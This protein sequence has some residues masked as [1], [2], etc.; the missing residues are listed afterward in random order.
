MDRIGKDGTAEG[1]GPAAERRAA[2]GTDHDRPVP[3]PVAARAV[4][5]VAGDFVV[6]VNPVDGSEIELCPPPALRAGRG[7]PAEPRPRTAA[8]RAADRA[9]GPRPAPLLERGA[10]RERLA[11]LLGRGRSVRLT[12][13]EGSGRTA[14]L[15][16]VA[17]DCAELAPEGVVRLNGLGRTPADLLHELHAAVRPAERHR[18]GRERLH[19]DIRETGAVV[20]LDDLEFGGAALGE[21]LAAAP[22][23]AFVLAPGPQA[24][25]PAPEDHLDEVVLEG[26]SRGASLE[27]LERAVGRPLTEDETNWAG[28]LWF[29]S[30]GLPLRFVQAGALLRQCDELRSDPEAFEDISPFEGARNTEVPLPTLGQ[31]AAPAPLLA[32]RLSAS[33]RK[34][35]RFAVALGGEVPHASQLPAL[36]G[37]THADASFGELAACGLLSPAGPRHRLAPGALVQLRER[38]YCDDT[39]EAAAHARTVARHYTWWVA[40]PSVGPARAAA[41]A[42]AVLAALAALV[43]GLSAPPGAGAGTGDGKGNAVTAVRLARA[44]APV[45]AAA[46]HWGAWERAL[47]AG[48]EAARVAGEVAEEAYF[49]H[50]LGV[51]ALCGD[52]TERARAELEASIALRGAL[53]DKKGTVAG[54]RALALVA[55]RETAARREAPTLRAIAPVKDPAAKA[56]PAAPAALAL[57]PAP[58]A[59]APEPPAP[60]APPRAVPPQPL[61]VAPAAS[62]P[63]AAVAATAAGGTVAP[64][65][66]EATTAQVP[67]ARR[68]E[69]T[70]TLVAYET[71]PP[72]RADAAEDGPRRRGG[73]LIGGARRN[74]A[75]AG[76]GALIAAVLGTVVTMGTVSDKRDTPGTGVGEGQS[77]SEDPGPGGLEAEAPAAP[78]ASAPVPGGSPA[79]PVTGSTSRPS[80][81]PSTLPSGFPPSSPDHRGAIPDPGSPPPGER[82]APTREPRPSATPSANPSPTPTRSGG[83]GAIRPS[84]PP[85]STPPPSSTSTG[86]SSAS[87]SGTAV[88]PAPQGP[89][90]ADPGPGGEPAP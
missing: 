77:A 31:G 56:L 69:S 61:P 1:A 54:R 83:A 55:D 66:G 60:A 42:D 5:L 16:L 7:L 32:S 26:L 51:L 13:P 64:Y 52:L 38:G 41:E 33:A 4:R 21:L 29:E 47:R 11:A 59:A 36:V 18:P 15:D 63:A 74:L 27:L 6:T 37:D 30:E 20:L 89:S 87:A 35:L 39:A 43:Q 57:P 40:H 79:V 17:E 49:H 50:E 8:D 3:A 9:T 70:E 44:A 14:V 81:A 72:G 80:G 46:L 85:R 62:V 22:E 86:S 84:Y 73:L 65:G 53:S 45:F 19:A 28:D 88:P 23:C 67:V 68:Y 82:P 71:A 24:P 75:A 58:V 12:G 10:V 76:A 48:S 34:T 90:G 78:T 25:G 2:P